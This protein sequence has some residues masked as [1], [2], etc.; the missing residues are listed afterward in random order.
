MDFVLAAAALILAG[1]GVAIAYDLRSVALFVALHF[2]LYGIVQIVMVVSSKMKRGLMKI[3]QWTLFL[4]ITVVILLGVFAVYLGTLA[5][6]R[7]ALLTAGRCF[8]ILFL[9]ELIDQRAQ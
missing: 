9:N 8:R 2:A 1:L 5:A 4:A 3:F 6:G 7:S